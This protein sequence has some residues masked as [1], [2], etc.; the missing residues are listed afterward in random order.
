VFPVTFPA[1]VGG[2]VLHS[3]GSGY[4]DVNSFSEFVGAA[5]RFVGMMS[6]RAENMD[7]RLAFLL[8]LGTWFVVE[9]VIR[10]LAGMLR[11]AIL[12]AALAGGGVAAASVLGFSF[13]EPVRM[14]ALAPAPELP[15]PASP[16]PA[17]HPSEPQFHHR[18]PARP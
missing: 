18:P 15:G 8:G 6:D 12:G 3:N 5:V 2:I 4:V 11:W 17:S 9:Q 16:V 1:A 10:R 7:G 14:P 13:D